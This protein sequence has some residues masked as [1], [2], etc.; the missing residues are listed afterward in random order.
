M[1]MKLAIFERRAHDWEALVNWYRDVLG[2]KVLMR[3][4]ADGYAMLEAGGVHLAIKQAAAGTNGHT[5]GH[6]N[7]DGSRLYFAVEDL[8][9]ELRR[10][11]DLG[12]PLVKPLKVT[13]ENYRR[14]VIAD[15]EG[16]RICL[17]DWVK[18]NPEFA[19]EEA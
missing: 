11:S 16:Q 15:P 1:N 2:L 13:P 10:L 19:V 12:V 8:E 3:V 7:G 4:E 14:A 6:T 5:N 9:A 17:F 18:T